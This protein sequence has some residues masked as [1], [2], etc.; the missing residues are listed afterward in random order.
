[1]RVDGS[2]F[3]Q[4]FETR[5]VYGP[6][7]ALHFSFWDY[8]VEVVASGGYYVTPES[9]AESWNVR[10][11]SRINLPTGHFPIRPYIGFGVD[12]TV[13]E[14]D[15]TTSGAAL[16]G[17]YFRLRDRFFPFA[18]GWYRTAPDLED[19]RFRFGVRIQFLSPY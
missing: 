9:P 15:R 19:F 4:R 13:D 2:L 3:G 6:G 8:A 12:R 1:M 5:P 16:G 18:E 7:G 17:A 10:V 11:D 14:G